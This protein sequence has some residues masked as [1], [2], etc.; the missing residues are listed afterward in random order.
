MRE[1]LIPRKWFNSQNIYIF[2][3]YS[4]HFFLKL[5]LPSSYML[6]CISRHLQL[7]GCWDIMLR[8]PFRKGLRILATESMPSAVSSLQGL[9]QVREMPYTWS[10]LLQI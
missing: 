7:H 4:K 3:R 1:S 2:F 6:N 8:C 9:P 10:H 5:C